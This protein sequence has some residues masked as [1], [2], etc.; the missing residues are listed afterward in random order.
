[1]LN[2][3]MQTVLTAIAYQAVDNAAL[4][5][6]VIDTQDLISGEYHIKF[7]SL[8][9]AMTVFRIMESDVKTNDT[10][11]G[12]TPTLVHDL[13][14][15]DADQ[16][17]KVWTLNLRRYLDGSHKR[18]IQLQATAGNG[19]GATSD[20]DANFVGVPKFGGSNATQRGVD[21]AVIVNA[22]AA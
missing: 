8:G 17:G 20:I 16:N 1:M 4:T 10:T 14:K 19:A 12:G 21:Q 6:Q 5:S 22:V 18:Y 11:L 3:Q 7:A 2:E 13:D 15:P 9:A